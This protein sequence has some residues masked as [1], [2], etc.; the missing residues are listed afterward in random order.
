[1][2]GWRMVIEKDCQSIMDNVNRIQ[3]RKK[4]MNNGIIT[5]RID[6]IKDDKLILSKR[7]VTRNGKN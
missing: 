5:S 7:E 2:M 4:E 6:T 3:R 1:M